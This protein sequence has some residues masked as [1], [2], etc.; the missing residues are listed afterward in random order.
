MMEDQQPGL[1]LQRQLTAVAIPVLAI[2]LGFAHGAGTWVGSAHADV[3][4]SSTTLTADPD[5]AAQN[6][7]LDITAS[8]IHVNGAGHVVDCGGAAGSA[9]VRIDN[10][11]DV[12]LHRLEVRNCEV[13]LSIAGGGGHHLNELFVHGS[14]FLDAVAGSGIG[15]HMVGTSGNHIVG[16]QSVSNDLC[17]IVLEVSH[18]NRFGGMVVTENNLRFIGGVHVP[19]CS[20]FAL[21]ASDDNVIT[22]SDVSR[23]GSAGIIL[24]DATGNTLLDNIVNDTNVSGF[25]SINI[26]IEG[27]SDRNVIRGNSASS[28]VPGTALDGI[29]I[30]CKAGGPV[31]C[32][33]ET[34]GA[35]G[36]LIQSNTANDN[37]RFGIAQAA[38]NTGNLYKNNAAAGN[39][40]ADLAIDP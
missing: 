5:C 38:G 14:V 22:S 2:A 1:R 40:L 3:I 37:A 12:H 35:D 25:P 9:G 6:P 21:A 36:N 10:Q 20:G 13:G 33:A 18:H 23:N 8:G 34:T 15:I 24:F 16:S 39:G 29:N 30:G 31:V 32:G 19:A 26:L 7:C 11:A 27:D 4:A 17:G 28:T